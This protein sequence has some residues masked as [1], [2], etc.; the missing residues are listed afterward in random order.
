MIN[1]KSL[2]RT[3]LYA[4]L[5]GALLIGGLTACQP[6]STSPN[7]AADITI[8]PAKTI[9]T[10]NP[11]QPSAKAVAVDS[12]GII[13]GVGD[14]SALKT[15]FSGAVIDEAFAGQTLLP[16]LIDPHVH[17]TLGAMMY[18]LE[19]IPPWD[20]QGP[21]GLV[22]GLPD[23][24]SLMARIKE[25]EAEAPEGPLILFGYHNLVQGDIDRSDLDEITTERPLFIWHYSG[26]DFYLNSAAIK[27][28]KL[29]PALA[30]KYHGVDLDSAGQLTGRIYE[31][32][33]L[34]LFASVGPVLLAPAHI[35]KGFAGYESLFT[36]AGVTTVA[37]MGYGIFGRDMEDNF[38]NQFYNDDEPYR[39]YLVPEHRAFAATHGEDSSAV[40]N[41]MVKKNSRIAVLP[42]VKLFTDAAF[43]SQTMRMAAPGYIGG[44]SKGTSGLWV[45]EPDALP[46]LMGK[47]WDAGLD[48]HIH[49]NGDAA[50]E[51]T[52]AA[53]AT[54]APPQDG[55]RIIIEHLGQMTP[56]QVKAA[57]ALPIGVSAASHYVN[58][59]GDD[60][61]TA[62]GEKT[63]F[64]TPLASTMA[65]GIRS[66][67]HSDAPLAP[68]VPLQAAAAH[69]TRLTRQGNISTPSERLTPEQALRA[70]TLDAAWSLGL[71]DELG[72]I[73][74]GKKADF[75]VLGA[76]PLEAEPQDWANIP[77]WGVVL[78]GEKHPLNE[79]E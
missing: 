58:Y 17:M 68:P 42:Q 22:K 59:M 30:E 16:G 26:H 15:S 44:Q 66:T 40:I 5:G 70:I 75:T 34:A 48:I 9:L 18:G 27:M 65:A 49:S 25:L 61:I 78:G 57:A 55:Q 29:T 6:A 71:E 12:N 38:L 13:K 24:N 54:L 76:N 31:D 21:K 45:T 23:K 10:Q 77:V 47:Y 36:K 3:K 41:E 14:L 2:S 60:Y 32:A 69:V 46:A 20:M 8:Y 64:I 67:L 56:D 63:A 50:Q 19:W 53:A 39:L 37:E 51:S 1:V 62:I 35:A 74:T 4:L 52:L 73:E 79:N 43:Y 33:G 7:M 11:A 72:S 28:S